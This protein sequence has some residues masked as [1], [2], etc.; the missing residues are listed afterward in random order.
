MLY[1]GYSD[2]GSELKKQYTRYEHARAKR[3]NISTAKSRAVER[4]M[5][6]HRSVLPYGI[7]TI[8]EIYGPLFVLNGGYMDNYFSGKKSTSAKGRA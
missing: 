2:L 8:G 5:Q 4:S 7:Y 3:N 6:K 1:F